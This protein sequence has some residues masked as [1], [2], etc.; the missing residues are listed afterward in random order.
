MGQL[1]YLVWLHTD[2]HN[3]DNITKNIFLLD[4]L[5]HHQQNYTKKRIG[6]HL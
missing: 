5:Y 6:H 3:F 2:I 1:Q 4:V